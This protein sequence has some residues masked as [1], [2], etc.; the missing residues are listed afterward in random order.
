[1]AHRSIGYRSRGSNLFDRG[2]VASA[3]AR[4]ARS[5]MRT[6]FHLRLIG[7]SKESGV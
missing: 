5:G 7:M 2:R 4:R 1:M 3:R 6:V